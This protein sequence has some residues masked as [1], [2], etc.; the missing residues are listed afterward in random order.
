MAISTS[1]AGSTKSLPGIAF[2]SREEV[3][4][5][6][7]PR[8]AATRPPSPISSVTSVPKRRLPPSSSA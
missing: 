1:C 6:S 8:T 2:R 5:T 7:Q 4:S 3:P